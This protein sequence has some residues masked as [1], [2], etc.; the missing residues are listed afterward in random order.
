MRLLLT[1][2]G[3]YI[4]SVLTP[5]ILD[6]GWSVTVVD[7]LLY[8]Q[9]GPAACAA[10][11]GFRFVLGDVR[12][13]GVMRSLVE[14]ADVLLPLAAIVGQKACERAPRLAR[15]VNVD[16]IALLNRLRRPDQFVIFPMT[17]SGYGATT[18]QVLCTEETELSPV[19][20][21]GRT[22]VE[23][24]RILRATPNVVVLRLATV[25][26][27]SPRLRLDL[28]VNDFVYRALRDRF[29]VV[30]EKDFKRNFLHIED[31]A[32]CFVHCIRH[33]RE[34]GGE[35]YNVGADEA[36]MSKEELVRLVKT[37]IP[38][39]YVHFAEVGSDP[40]RRNYIVSNEKL[41]RAGFVAR[42]TLQQGIEELLRS[43]A[44]LRPGP[45]HNA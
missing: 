36:N 39:L 22:K 26:G 32:D 16:A 40:D 33:A 37:Y 17:N 6:Q 38:D 43:Y 11:P 27:P 42:R 25:F 9:S 15:E 45:Y 2:G 13:E 31:A 18:G 4:G 3:G 1:G 19:S 21:Y 34:M 14:E 24:E 20:L 7:N 10:R 5:R 35:V 23:A 41:R 8:G 30:F 29:L 12:E 28:L 44:M